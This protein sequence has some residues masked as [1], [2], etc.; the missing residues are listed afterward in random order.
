MK[1]LKCTLDRVHQCCNKSS[2]WLWLESTWVTIFDLTWLDSIF[3]LNDLT[4]LESSVKWLESLQLTWVMTHTHKVC[5]VNNVELWTMIVPSFNFRWENIKLVLPSHYNIKMVHSTP[6]RVFMTM[7]L[8]KYFCHF[9]KGNTLHH[10]DL[11]LLEGKMTWLHWFDLKKIARTWLD[12][13]LEYFWLDL[14]WL[15]TRARV[16]CYN[17][18][19]HTHAMHTYTQHT[20]DIHI[21]AQSHTQNTDKQ[22][23]I[24]SEIYIAQNFSFIDILSCALQHHLLT[25]LRETFVDK[26]PC[27]T[28]YIPSGIRTHDPLIMIWEHEPLHYSA[29]TDT[30]RHTHTHTH[31]HTH[32]HI[33]VYYFCLSFKNTT[34][35]FQQHHSQF[36]MTFTPNYIHWYFQSNAHPWLFIMVFSFDSI[37]LTEGIPFIQQFWH[38]L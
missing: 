14:T 3:H 22:I 27:L 16:T 25:G 37:I 23:I 5:N 8:T 10:T 17:T 36:H 28:A 6:V 38:N 34:Y 30:H 24:L 7:Q 9:T 20:H 35:R 4:S 13:R 19:V 1:W 21:Q 11:R 26:M 2:H 18:V 12:S 33:W 29:P 15:V 31:T 32:I